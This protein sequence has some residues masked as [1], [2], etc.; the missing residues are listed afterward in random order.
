MANKNASKL[1][2]VMQISIGIEMVGEEARFGHMY[3]Q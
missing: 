3:T 1:R 2:I